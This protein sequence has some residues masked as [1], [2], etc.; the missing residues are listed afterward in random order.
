MKRLLNPRHVRNIISLFIALVAS[1]LVI[2]ATSV[3]SK[4]LIAELQKRYAETSNLV[5]DGYTQSVS[6]LLDSYEATLDAIYDKEIFTKGTSKEI[7]KYL[8]QISYKTPDDFLD[9]FFFDKNGIAYSMDMSIHGIR[10]RDYY[11]SIIIR[12]EKFY[13]GEATISRSDEQTPVF[14]MSK[15][16]CNTDGTIKGGLCGTIRLSSLENPFKDVRVLNSGSIS[17]IDKYGRFLSNRDKTLIS[18]VYVPENEAYRHTAS[19]EIAYMHDGYVYSQDLDGNEVQII[20][21]TVPK[22]GWKLLLMIPLK[23]MIKLEREQTLLKFFMIII[24]IAVIFILLFAEIRVMDFFQRKELLFTDYDSVTNLWTR[25]KFEIEAQRMIKR[26][27]NRKF[28]LIDS[29]IRGFKFINQNYGEAEANKVLKLVSKTLVKLTGQYKG[30]SCRGFADHFY[31]FFPITSVR[32]AMNAF[33]E[34]LSRS[35]AYFQTSK[36][37]FSVKC[38]I[39][40]LLKGEK[41]ED[42]TIRRLIG[43]ATVAKS[44]LNNGTENEYIIY[45]SKMFKKIQNEQFLE[46]QSE[47]AL[48]NEEFFVVYQPKIDLKTEK[49]VGAEALVRW[50]HPERGIIPPNDFIP[51]FERNGFVTKLDYYVYEQVFKFLDNRIKQG[52]EIVPVSMNMSRCHNKPELFV[53]EFLEIF[54]KYSVPPE[55]IQVEIL[56][57]SKGSNETLIEI[58]ELLHKEGFS[59]AMDDFGSGESSLNMLSKV[60]IDVLKFDRGFLLSSTNKNGEIDRRSAVF[61]ES[62]INLSKNLNKE[63]VFEGVET[64]AQRDFLRIINC[65]QVQ[66]YLYSKP[67]PEEEFVGFITKNM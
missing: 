40:F 29:D 36:V 67:L 4:K 13:I 16:I 11:Y 42:L 65:D 52:K 15:M 54:H 7:Q 26:R 1:V 12:G 25:E 64:E 47:T 57:T 2:A 14:I 20:F 48:K 3:I 66:G 5:I 44:N 27:G 35:S 24:S 39:A 18:H 10:D 30:I 43:R 32:K 62:L 34:G 56:E 59:V 28:V 6:I 45:D 55:Y 49:V 41:Y 60:P 38:G 50:R 8:N 61:I 63:T 46:Q 37:P 9:F 22:A 53:E 23:N 33:R 51:L 31:C 21:R 58:A 19:T 17:L